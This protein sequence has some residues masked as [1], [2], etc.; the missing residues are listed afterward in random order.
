MTATEHMAGPMLAVLRLYYSRFP[1]QR[2]FGFLASRLTGGRWRVKVDGD[3]QMTVDPYD[4]I[5]MSIVKGCYERRVKDVFLGLLEPGMVVVDVGA[6]SGYYTLLAAKGVG[7][8]GEVHAFEPVSVIFRR[9]K[10]NVSLNALENVRL[11]NAA[12]WET[13]AELPIYLSMST[14]SGLTSFIRSKYTEEKPTIVKALSLDCYVQA[15]QT[16]RIDL[17]KI[18]VEGAELPV[19]KGATGILRSYSPD[20]ICE[21]Y[22]PILPQAGYT[23]DD[24]LGFMAGFGYRAFYVDTPFPDTHYVYFSTSPRANLA[25]WIDRPRGDS[26]RRSPD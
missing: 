16:K 26:M 17:L 25:E 1:D 4:S 2:G 6:H 3:L 8:K 7:A 20:V 5:E 19:L 18:D 9:L 15:V 13:E 10:E 24:L 22:E 11:N 12:L 23:V 14:N 21:I